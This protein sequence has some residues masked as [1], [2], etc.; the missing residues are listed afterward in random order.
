MR[1]ACPSRGV[2]FAAIA[3]LA[4]APGGARGQGFGLNDI[5]S[6]A[7]ARAYA[8]AGVPCRDASVIFWSPGAA[9][10]LPGFSVYGGGAAIAVL[11][12]FTADT[13]L[14]HY[15]ANPPTAVPPHLFVNYAGQLGGHGAS[16]GIGAYVPYG[17]TSQW[18]PDFPGRF[19]AQKAQLQSIYVQPNV[20]FEIVRNVLSVGGGP[21]IGYSTV[22]LRQSLDFSTIP[23][24]SASVP[25]GTTFGDLGF[26][27]G[28]EFGRTKLSGHATA[29]GFTFGAQLR[30]VHDLQIGARFL[31]ALTFKYD[32]ATA[33]FTEVPTGLVLAGGNP[34]GLPAGT[35]VDSIIA[36]EF[37]SGGPL[38]TQPVSTRIV[39]P[40]QVEAG[41]GYTGFRQ[42]TLD[43]DYEYIGYQSFQNLPVTFGGP[44]AVLSRVLLEDFHDS[45]SVRGSIEHVFG[46]SAS[47]VV[48]RAG[49]GYVQT[50]APDVTVTPLLPDMNRY[51]G[52]VGIGVPLGSVLALDAA[53]LHVFTTG[54]RGRITERLS[55]AQTAA[56]L[57]SGFYTL[58]ANVLSISLRVHL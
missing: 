55:A 27:Q 58:A 45:W 17:L 53:Y 35:P 22:E 9:A 15:A 2:L 37:R 12:G 47:G 10:T 5:G 23:V 32:N 50:P 48:G 11:G 41:V 26:A 3:I 56:E 19:E 29:Y 25:P 24:P 18:R 31:S 39:H 16:I 57:N 13:T 4:L 30:P 36:P 51:N 43:I 8:T 40:L 46:D 20:A 38:V 49:F 7:V 44:A 21:V 1:R 42:T 34:L 33:T 6:C 14:T 28:T 54:R 52:S